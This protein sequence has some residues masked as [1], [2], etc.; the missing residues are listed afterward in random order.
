M[1]STAA[2]EILIWMKTM[3]TRW[4]PNDA[5]WD[6]WTR[7]LE[8]LADPGAVRQALQTLRDTTDWTSPK[9]AQLLEIL[10]KSTTR[11]NRSNARHA[12]HSGMYIQCVS[13][14]SP[15]STTPNVAGE[16]RYIARR[17]NDGFLGEFRTLYWPTDHDMPPEHVILERMEEFRVLNQ[18]TYG[19]TWQLVRSLQ[20]PLD[21]GAMIRRR[22]ELRPASTRRGPLWRLIQASIDKLQGLPPQ[23]YAADE[24]PAEEY[25][26]TPKR[27]GPEPDHERKPI[28]QAITDFMAGKPQPHRPPPDCPGPELPVCPDL[29][30][31]PF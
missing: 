28:R 18:A 27:S 5:E 1:D 21:D 7:L 22:A 16:P 20:G 6:S 26:G 29:G 14:K 15:P 17:A 4:A 31:E 24:Q 9:R 19:G 8:R 2:A 13:C 12:G 23:E 3:W 10:N 25:K 11:G 30:E